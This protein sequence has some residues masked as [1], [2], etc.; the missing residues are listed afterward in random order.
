MDVLRLGKLLAFVLRHRPDALVLALSKPDLGE[1][2]RALRGEA[3]IQ[4]LPLIA[5]V[6]AEE[7]AEAL[8]WADCVLLPEEMTRLLPDGRLVVLDG[9]AHAANFTAPDRLVRA[10]LPFLNEGR[11]VAEPAGVG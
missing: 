4:E 8:S 3:E 2:L 11:V 9:V 7:R 10:A 5:L 1:A 6:Q